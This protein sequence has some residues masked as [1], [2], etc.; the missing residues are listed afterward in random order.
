MILKAYVCIVIDTFQNILH[1]NNLILKQLS[2][3]GRSDVIIIC[4]HFIHEETEVQKTSVFKVTEPGVVTHGLI[5]IL[6]I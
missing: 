2:E 1:T 4:P 3:G 6:K 5:P